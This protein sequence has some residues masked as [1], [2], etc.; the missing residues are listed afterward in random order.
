MCLYSVTGQEKTVL[1][2][3]DI[4]QYSSAVLYYHQE[5]LISA[6]IN[7]NGE[8]ELVAVYLIPLL[9]LDVINK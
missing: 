8:Y 7:S 1:E 5:K 3:F 4:I 9:C 6:S 2:G